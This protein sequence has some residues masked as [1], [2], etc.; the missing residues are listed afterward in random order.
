VISLE[1][2]AL[3]I[4]GQKFTRNAKNNLHMYLENYL[5]QGFSQ[6]LPFMTVQSL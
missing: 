4:F 6:L 5:E 3:G 2:V 1:K